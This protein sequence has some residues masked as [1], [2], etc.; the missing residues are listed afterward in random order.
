MAVTCCIAAAGVS[1]LVRRPRRES[2]RDAHHSSI[3]DRHRP[4]F[5]CPRADDDWTGQWVFPPT[6]SRFTAQ[7]RGRESRDEL[8]HRHCSGC[9][10]GRKSDSY[11]SR[12]IPRPLRRFRQEVRGGETGGFPK[13][14]TVEIAKSVKSPWAWANRADAWII[15]GEHDKAVR[16]L[17]EVIHYFPS[18]FSY[19]ER[20]APCCCR[21]SSTRRLKTTM[22][23]SVS[24]PRMLSHTSVA[25]RPGIRTPFNKALADFTN[26]IRLQPDEA[27]SYYSRG[28]TWY[29]K[30]ELDQAI[31]D[32]TEAI[33]LDPKCAMAYCARGHAW[34]SKQK[35]EKAIEDYTKSIELDATQSLTFANRGSAWKH[36]GKLDKASCRL[37]GSDQTRSQRFYTVC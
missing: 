11:S 8:G 27:D 20:G 29:Q 25:A 23:Q 3:T 30:L 5:D 24:N 26:A 9:D 2:L 19:C 1:E 17:S 36:L 15:K 16:D 28:L 21:E 18:A 7:T 6:R 13:F 14:F 37:Y 12:T 35:D 33:R 22:K 32:F 10:A 4:C 34:G 31:E